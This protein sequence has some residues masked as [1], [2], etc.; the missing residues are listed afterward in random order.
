MLAK[1]DDPRLKEEAAQLKTESN[2]I[3]NEREQSNRASLSALQSIDSNLKGIEGSLSGKNDPATAN[4]LPVQS[5]SSI[6]AILLKNARGIF[7]ENYQVRRQSFNDLMRYWRSDPNTIPALLQ[8]A[9]EQPNL[10]KKLDGVTNAIRIMRYVERRF[11]KPNTTNVSE[12]VKKIE[13]LPGTKGAILARELRFMKDR[14]RRA[15][16]GV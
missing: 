12:L 16:T 13:D 9:N 3:F 6:D 15:A 11:L 8:A 10:N 2:A 7:N 4:G 14:L 1:S 5:V